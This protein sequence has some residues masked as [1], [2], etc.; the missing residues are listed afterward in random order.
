[1]LCFLLCFV[2]TSCVNTWAQSTNYMS[3]SFMSE[4][5]LV[6]RG[7]RVYRKRPY[8]TDQAK[9]LHEGSTVLRKRLVNHKPTAG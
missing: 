6:L 9:H 2:Q 5:E 7:K 4:D 8:P 3:M 1:M